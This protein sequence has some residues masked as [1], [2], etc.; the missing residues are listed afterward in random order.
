MAICAVTA[1]VAPLPL[2]LPGSSDAAT[3]VTPSASGAFT[4][5]KTV[6]RDKVVS[7]ANQVV[8]SNTVTLSVSQ[9]TDLEGRQEIAVSWSGAHPTGGIVA[10]ENSSQAANEEFPFVL[11]ECRGIDSTTVPAATQLTPQTC[12]TQSWTERYQGSFSD[13]YPAYR[14]DEYSPTRGKAIVG[15]PTTIPASCALGAGEPV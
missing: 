15:A 13:T 9:T 11:L 1:G 6:T 7:G 3:H 2:L 4:T 14:L 10:N 8:A 5:T 12:W